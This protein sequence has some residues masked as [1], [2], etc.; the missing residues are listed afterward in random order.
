MGTV[1]KLM[2]CQVCLLLTTMGRWRYMAGAASYGLV[3]PY[4]WQSSM[5]F[6]YVWLRFGMREFGAVTLSLS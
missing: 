3:Y 6:V 1:P 2:A 5:L 4:G